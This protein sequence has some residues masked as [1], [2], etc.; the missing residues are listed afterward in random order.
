LVA[1]VDNLAAPRARSSAP[2]SRRRTATCTVDSPS[3]ADFVAAGAIDNGESGFLL[4]EVVNDLVGAID[5][6]YGGGSVSDWADAVEDLQPGALL[7]GAQYVEISLVYSANG[8][9]VFDELDTLPAGLNINLTMSGLSTPPNTEGG[10]YS[11]PTNIVDQ[12]GNVIVSTEPSGL[13]VWTEQDATFAGGGVTAS[14]STLSI[15]APFAIQST[16][17][18]SIASASP[19]TVPEN[20]AATTTIT[21]VFPTAV[22]LNAA[23]AAA[24]YSVTVGGS[25]VTF[26]EVGGV[27]ITAF[28]GGSNQININVPAIADPGFYDVTVT[29]LAD[30]S[31]TATAAGLI[32]VLATSTL[33]TEV[34]NGTG[35]ITVNPTNSPGLPVGT[36]FTNSVVTASGVYDETKSFI[37]KTFGGWLRNGTSI[38]GTVD[39][40]NVIVGDSSDD[41]AQTTLSLQ[42]LD[43]VNLEEFT[44]SVN[45]TAGGT[46]TAV[47]APNGVNDPTKYIEGS[48]ITISA[49]AAN[50]FTF[51]GWTGAAVANANSATTTL[52]MPTA[53]ASVTA[54]FVQTAYSIDLTVV[55]NVGGTVAVL[56][57]PNHPN[58]VDYILGTVITI[59]ATA[60]DGYAFGG[61]VGADAGE[62]D[63]VSNAVASFTIDGSQQGYTIQASFDVVDSCLSGPSITGISPAEG[64]IFGG[65]VARITGTCL[66][67]DTIITIGG[68]SD[69][70]LPPLLE[71]HLD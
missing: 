52:V 46:A 60:E 2:S 64:W 50:G 44:L 5:A 49:V 34:L 61:W 36:Y 38:P 68:V 22:A 53:D 58:G 69:D 6:V 26:N 21:G 57:P 8:G 54:N 28:S 67:D 65:V 62:L 13:G 29:D 31:N 35:T 40:V 25:P 3:L 14:L 32:E 55:G 18:I 63:D 71:R 42:L 33:A 56:T 1:N 17:P 11:Y 16:P 59:Q 41:D 70:R 37:T 24:A 20:V 12:S 43:V 7:T 48:T 66:Q 19:N 39:S 47:T 10:L 51:N 23:Q 27:A 15:F 4:V 45:A 9:T 30:G